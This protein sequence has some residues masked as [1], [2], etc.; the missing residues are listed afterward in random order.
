MKEKEK[1]INGKKAV[2][3]FH[4]Q[5]QALST[6]SHKCTEIILFFNRHHSIQSYSAT[7][8]Y[9]VTQKR[10]IQDRNNI[11]IYILYIIYIMKIQRKKKQYL[12][13]RF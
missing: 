6:H 8:V 4:T 1:Q 7:N 12:K 3:N 9:G 10:K 5:K 13:Q 2:L 11:Y